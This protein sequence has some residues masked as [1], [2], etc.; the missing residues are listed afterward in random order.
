[1]DKK[2]L[3]TVSIG[4]IDFSYSKRLSYHRC[5]LVC[6]GFT[7]L[8]KNG[9]WSTWSP[10]RFPIPERDEDFRP[11]LVETMKASAPRPEVAGGFQHPAMKQGRKLNMTCGNCQL[12]CHPEED[13]RKRR[14][15][16]LTKNGV[17]VQHAD[18]T[19]QAVSPEIAKKHLAEMSEEQRAMY[20]EV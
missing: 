2:E 20:E 9:K 8:A 16:M 4:G 3:T 11:V 18:G 5:D 15:K 7:G 17:V 14:Y 13:E 12:I 1:M 19:L 10:G 6:G